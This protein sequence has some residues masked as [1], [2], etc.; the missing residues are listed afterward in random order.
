[1]RGFKVKNQC[2]DE[3]CKKDEA[4]QTQIDCPSLLKVL[5]ARGQKR[6][7]LSDDPGRY[8]C[9]YIYYCSLSQKESKEKD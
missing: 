6:V 7:S 4:K 2:I 1:M 3:N 5:Q 9:N 8:I